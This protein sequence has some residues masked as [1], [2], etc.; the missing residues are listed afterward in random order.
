[1][2][3][4]LGCGFQK[5]DGWNNVDKVAHCKPDQIV[6][7]E[8]FPWPWPDSCADEVLLSHVMEHIGGTT[9]LFLNFVTELWRVCTPQADIT[10][11]AP[12]PRCDEFLWDPTHVRAITPE[13]LRMFNQ[14]RNY[15]MIAEHK[16]ETPLGIYLG[17]DFDLAEVRYVWRKPWSE[18]HSKGRI[19][20]QQLL[21]LLCSQWNVAKEIVMKLMVIKPAG[22]R[23]AKMRVD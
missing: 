1:M 12:H 21:E 22:S 10:I 9:V 7:L 23:C 6:D 19:S 14:L 15:Q 8:E 17:V 13:G 20:D 11:L 16:P 18:Q 3:L 4:N 2:K 5:L